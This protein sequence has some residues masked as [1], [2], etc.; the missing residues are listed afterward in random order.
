M[1]PARDELAVEHATQAAASSGLDESPV[2]VRVAAEH[3][4]TMPDRF[5][6]QVSKN[7]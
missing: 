5:G 1:R 3:L 6:R 4:L 2:S 7:D